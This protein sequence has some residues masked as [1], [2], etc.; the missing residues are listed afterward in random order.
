MRVASRQV[1][2]AGITTS[3][4][5]VW[6]EPIARHCFRTETTPRSCRKHLRIHAFDR[7]E[8]T[9][10]WLAFT[11]NLDGDFSLGREHQLALVS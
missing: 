10:A 9:G 11:G 2:I 1:C 7:F 3:P 6:M 5:Q 8:H 4:D